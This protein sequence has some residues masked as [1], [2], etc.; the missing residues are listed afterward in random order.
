MG[1]T[2]KT[3]PI[4]FAIPLLDFLWRNLK[5]AKKKEDISYTSIRF[6]SD[7]S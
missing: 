5:N 3:C 6:S 2:K 7:E 1:R 4:R